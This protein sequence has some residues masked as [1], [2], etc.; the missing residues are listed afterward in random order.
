[1]AEAT[2]GSLSASG[3]VKKRSARTRSAARLRLDIADPACG[4]RG[5]RSR[6]L[7]DAPLVAPAV[8]SGGEEDLEAVTGELGAKQAAAQDQHIGIVVL[9]G[10]PGGQTVMDQRAADFAV[11]VDGDRHADAG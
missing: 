3:A 6:H 9:A 11:T 5:W 4:A 2:S 1:M 10:K 8:E 7:G